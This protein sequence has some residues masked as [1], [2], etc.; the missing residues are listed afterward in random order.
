MALLALLLEGLTQAC[1]RPDT[2]AL[3]PE[4]DKVRLQVWEGKKLCQW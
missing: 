4:V 2:R 1:S 3:Y